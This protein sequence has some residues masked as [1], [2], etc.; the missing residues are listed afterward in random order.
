MV[1]WLLDVRIGRRRELSSHPPGCC[2]PKECLCEGTGAKRFTLSKVQNSIRTIDVFRSTVSRKHAK[3]RRKFVSVCF[4]KHAAVRRK[5]VSVCF[6]KHAAVRRKFVSVC[7]QKHA[8][9]RRKFVSVCFMVCHGTELSDS[10]LTCIILAR[11]QVSLR[12]TKENVMTFVSWLVGRQG[13]LFTP[14]GVLFSR[15]PAKRRVET[16]FRMPEMAGR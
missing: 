12:L 9:A 5:F 3:V 13:I 8:A 4:P 16:C 2:L 11:L 6:Q 7:F 14:S 1:Q 15:V 10:T